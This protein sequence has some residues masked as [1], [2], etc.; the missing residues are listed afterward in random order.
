MIT[1]NVMRG[2]GCIELSFDDSIM[3]AMPTSLQ[4][5]D[6]YDM[7]KECLGDGD[8]DS[9]EIPADMVRRFLLSTGAYGA[10]DIEDDSDN[11]IRFVAFGLANAHDEKQSTVVLECY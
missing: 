1:A 9:L 8:Q 2:L 4:G 7:A 3:N 6:W 10:E 5:W 11:L